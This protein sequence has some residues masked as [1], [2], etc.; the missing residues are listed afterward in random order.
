LLTSEAC[1]I[2]AVYAPTNPRPRSSL[3]QEA[4]NGEVDV[5]PVRRDGTGR[6]VAVGLIEIVDTD[7]E[8]RWTTVGG[9]ELP[10]ETFDEAIERCLKETLGPD[11]RGQLSK[12]RPIGPISRRLVG[13]GVPAGPPSDRSESDEPCAVEIGG[14]LAPQ[15]VAHRFS[16]FLVTALPAQRQIVVAK[17]PVLADFLEAQGESGLAARLRLF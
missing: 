14:R 4:Q 16:W 15:G 13:H 5:V 2:E 17:R 12:P 3:S 8:N 1:A 6:L 9:A 11:A 10:G 7:G